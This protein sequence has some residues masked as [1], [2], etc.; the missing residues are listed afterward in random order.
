VPRGSDRI[1]YCSRECA[2]TDRAAK[3]KPAKEPKL[4]KWC[5]QPTPSQKQQFCS[6]E[7]QQDMAK[8]KA[9]ER[10]IAKFNLNL[11]PRQCKQ[12]GKTF[13]PVYSVKFRKFCSYKCSRIYSKRISGS[14]RR[15]REKNLPYEAIDPISIFER[16]KW[17]CHVCG[18]RAPKS[19]RG[20]IDPLAPELDHI[21]PLSK[22]GHHVWANVACCHRECNQ[23]KSDKINYNKHS[24][25]ME[26]TEKKGKAI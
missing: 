25:K 8:S 21:M 11:K 18:K 3:P 13:L 24:S 12:C 10:S 19:L 6:N 5:K 17:K 1:T 14:L 22:G 26:T 2:F 20:T 9:K 23:S 16:D 7:C 4:C 15:A